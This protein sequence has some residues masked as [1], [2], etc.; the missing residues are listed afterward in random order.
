MERRVRGAWWKGVL[1]I[2][3]LFCFARGGS[4]VDLHHGDGEGLAILVGEQRFVV[5]VVMG[6]KD[7]FSEVGE[8]SLC[9]LSSGV[10]GRGAAEMRFSPAGGLEN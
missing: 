4:G 6:W 7:P 2:S 10:W 3:C 5:F 8:C 9:R 1:V